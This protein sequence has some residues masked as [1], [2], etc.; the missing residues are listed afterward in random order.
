MQNIVQPDKILNQK[1]LIK[2]ILLLQNL[3]LLSCHIGCGE[4]VNDIKRGQ[5]NQG[6]YDKGNDQEKGNGLG[7]SL[8]N[9]LKHSTPITR[10][11]LAKPVFV[12]FISLQSL[13]KMGLQR[14]RLV[15]NQH[16]LHLGHGY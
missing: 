4:R 16:L 13:D 5:L 10:T 11:R 3:D 2:A 7:H 9:V 6:K 14:Y 15:P 12:L 1:W 8:K